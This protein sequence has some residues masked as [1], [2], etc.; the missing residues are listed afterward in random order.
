MSGNGWIDL[1]SDTLTSPG[2]EM[3]QAMANAAVGD[4]VY[5]EDPTVRELE[6]RAAETLGF[7]RALFVP[8]GTMGNQ[9]A[10]HLHAGRGT[11]VIVEQS[12]HVYRYELG[13]MA[14][15]SGVMPRVIEGH[16]GFISPEQ[17]DE[18][19]P[20]DV[21]YMAPASLLVVENT[22]NHSGGTVLTVEAT[23]ALLGRARAHALKAHLDGA[24]IFN[25]ATALGVPAQRLGAGFDTVT[26]CLSKGLG[27]PV[28]SML[29]GSAETIARAR[30]VRKRMGGGMRQAGVLAAAGLYAL[31]HNVQR[32]AD[33]HARAGRLAAALAEHPEFEIDPRSVR[34]NIVIARLADPS[35]AESAL[36]RLRSAGVLA[37]PMGPGRLRFVTHLDVDD[38]AIETAIRAV[39]RLA[40]R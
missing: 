21:Y 36:E 13:A 22:N 20:P 11:D 15:W 3:R 25:A 7:E 5:G 38:V 18:A 35:L 28:G 8:T 17:I 10:I 27:A 2:P 9:V 19:V 23:E 4:D 32:L 12:A 16:D 6:E 14:A 39:R 40:L 29:C 37:G 34:T 24:R 30:V 26:F 33:D 1:R 31:R